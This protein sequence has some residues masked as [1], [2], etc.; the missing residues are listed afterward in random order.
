[1]HLAFLTLNVGCWPPLARRDGDDTLL[2]AI[3]ILPLSFAIVAVR[4]FQ[5][6]T[7]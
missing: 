3:F 7:A 4:R 5:G 1:L 6:I 2:L